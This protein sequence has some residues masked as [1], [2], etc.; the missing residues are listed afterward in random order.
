MADAEALLLHC[1]LPLHDDARFAG[2][3]LLKGTDGWVWKEL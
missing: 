1:V 2:L 3:E